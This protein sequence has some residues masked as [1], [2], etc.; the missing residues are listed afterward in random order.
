MRLPHRLAIAVLIACAMALAV[1]TACRLTPSGTRGRLW[2]DRVSFDLP[3]AEAARLG[4]PV[5]AAEAQ[6]IKLIA[7]RE[8]AT[9]YAEFSITFAESETGD[10]L[11]H[12]RVTDEVWRYG[13]AGRSVSL[14]ALGG[15]GMVSAPVVI[16]YAI[17]YAPPC[18]RASREA[19]AEPPPTSSRINW[20][21]RSTSTRA[22]IPRATSTTPPT[23]SPS[24]TAPS[25]GTS[26]DPHY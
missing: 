20:C 12:V 1:A 23:A 4:G 14:G 25:T 6:T 16:G 11:Y 15:Q 13:G 19:S 24:I 17:H 18:S 5:T 2:F 8:L 3:S 21:R 26:R 7:L 9:A 22:A 10:A